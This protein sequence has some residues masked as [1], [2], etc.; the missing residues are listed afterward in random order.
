MK[1]LHIIPHLNEEGGGPAR[2]IATLAQAQA[3]RGD[4]VLVLCCCKGSGQQTLHPGRYENMTVLGPVTTSRLWWYDRKVK[5]AIRQAAR[6]RDILHVHGT[7]R[8]HSLGSAAVAEEYGIPF[9]LR[10]IGNFGIGPRNHK[11]WLKTPY[12]ALFER[13]AANKAAGIHCLSIKERNEQ[14]GLGLTSRKFIVP[15]PVDTALL[16]V[17]TEDVVLNQLCPTLR[18]EDRVILYLGRISFIK[19]LDVLLEAFIRLSRDFSDWRLVIAGPNT[20]PRVADALRRRIQEADVGKRVWLT[21]M[22]SGAVKAAFLRRADVFAQ[23]SQHENFGVSVAEALLFGKPCVV[24]DGVALSE[25]IEEADAGIS[26][27]SYVNAFERSLRQMLGDVDF[28]R[29]CSKAASALSNRFRPECVAEALDREYQT[30][31]TT[32]QT[33][34]AS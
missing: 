29:R 26:C 28:Q 8:Y 31:L 32:G 14:E 30:C 11:R 12:F 17:R 13:P 34:K 1:I 21:G 16:K 3:S 33:R 15:N 18:E 24:S 25:D 4:N 9:V 5:Q 20:F 10:T 22:V 6:D 23:P 27:P 19:N 2:A 7:W